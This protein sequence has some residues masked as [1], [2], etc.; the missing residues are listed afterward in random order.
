MKYYIVIIIVI[1][2]N[3][4][5]NNLTNNNIRIENNDSISLKLSILSNK[6]DSFKVDT[7]DYFKR[8]KDGIIRNS[9]YIPLSLIK[10]T[11]YSN[12]DT[13]DISYYS[14]YLFLAN[15]PILYK[16]DE[17]IESFRLM[18]DI[19]FSFPKI[20]RIQKN[21]NSVLLISKTFSN[22]KDYVFEVY[23][24]EVDIITDTVYLELDKWENILLILDS[25]NYWNYQTFY[26]SNAFDGVGYF[27]EGRQAKKYRFN[28]LV[29][30][31]G[32][33]YKNISKICSFFYKYSNLQIKEVNF[34]HNSLINLADSYITNKNDST[35]YYIDRFANE[36]EECLK[37]VNYYK[38]NDLY[39]G[40]NKWHYDFNNIIRKSLASENS[41]S[42]TLYKIK[43]QSNDKQK[44]VDNLNQLKRIKI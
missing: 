13:D 9:A 4:T 12:L 29:N 7:I 31:D 43:L 40:I 19:S 34:Y 8:N 28:E 5:N 15:E 27:F 39:N 22:N 42:K 25:I 35:L 18:I 41:I 20:F 11:E 32:M 21:T 36:L 30:P 16:C 37:F 44:I 26:T 2:T 38:K 33:H 6:C 17:N 24:H 14:T 23:K 3:C 10:H 1:L